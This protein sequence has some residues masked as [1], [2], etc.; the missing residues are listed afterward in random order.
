MGDIEHSI[1]HEAQDERQN[2]RIKITG[3]FS[4]ENKESKILDISLGGVKLEDFSSTEG[5]I[6]SGALNFVVDGI[7]VTIPVKLRVISSKDSV[8]R[9]EFIDLDIRSQKSIRCIVS[10]F[11]A[12]DMASLDEIITTLQKETHV[13]KRK[14]K[15]LQAKTVKERVLSILG[16]LVFLVIGLGLA[17]VLL[18]KI[19][20]FLF[21]AKSIFG[22]VQIDKYSLRMPENGLV[23]F[24]VDGKQEKVEAGQPLATMSS[25]LMSKLTTPEDFSALSNMTDEDM[26]VILGKALI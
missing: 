12:G 25:H 10:S 4:C 1:V 17:S 26:S 22:D 19:Y 8:T 16:T 11:V 7:T 14:P 5:L 18:T 2:I 13:K 15:E 21:S 9:A 23:K 20:F 24:L 6:K 3:F